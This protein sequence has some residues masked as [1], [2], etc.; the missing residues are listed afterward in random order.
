M[1]TCVKHACCSAKG[2]ELAMPQPKPCGMA[3]GFG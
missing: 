3:N 2:K 1:N